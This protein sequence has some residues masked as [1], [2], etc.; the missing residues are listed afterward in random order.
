MKTVVVSR[1][2]WAGIALSLVAVALGITL[3]LASAPTAEAAI[4]CNSEAPLG[5]EVLQWDGG[6]CY[7][8]WGG[9]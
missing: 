8:G 1:I 5:M 6:G 4:T 3:W 2:A 7:F 9:G